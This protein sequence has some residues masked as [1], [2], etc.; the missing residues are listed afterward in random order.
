[1]SNTIKVKTVL[2]KSKQKKNTG[3]VYLRII[4]K[5]NDRRETI[6]LSTRQTITTTQWKGGNEPVKGTGKDVMRINS[7]IRNYVSDAYDIFN[8]YCQNNKVLSIDK[9]KS[10]LNKKLFG[11]EDKTADSKMYLHDLFKRYIDIHK[12]ELSVSRKGRYDF[13]CKKVM[14]FCA[15][16]YGA[17]KFEIADLNRDFHL[18]FKQYFFECYEYAQ[19]TVNNYLKV[20]DATVRDA[21]F[22]GLLDRFPFLNCTY[23]Y[24][25]GDVRFLREEQLNEI[26]TYKGRM[27]GVL[28]GDSKTYPINKEP[29]WVFISPTVIVQVAQKWCRAQMFLIW[30]S[31]KYGLS[32]A[33]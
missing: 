23:T 12:K 8:D 16:E 6:E 2:K 32:V 20:L 21:Y 30:W 19:D 26:R 31:V 28:F 9:I 1:M 7:D 14:E 10:V 11:V 4:I 27:R 24:A 33:F 25:D 13:V 5:L 18:K 17:P 22:S 29:A 3:S 15:E